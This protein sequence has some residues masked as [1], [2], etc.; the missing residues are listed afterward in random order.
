VEAWWR[1]G[2]PSRDGYASPLVG[3]RLERGSPRHQPTSPVETGPVENARIVP[4]GRGAR[5]PATPRREVSAEPMRG[6]F[7]AMEQFLTVQ[8]AVMQAALAPAPGLPSVVSLSA[9]A[10]AS[11]AAVAIQSGAI[12]R[13]AAQRPAPATA[14]EL[15]PRLAPDGRADWAARYPLLGNVTAYVQGQTLQAERRLTTAEDVF[16][17]DHRFTQ[18]ISADPTLEPVAVVPMTVSLEIMAEAAAALLPGLRVVG[19]RRVYCSRWITV[20]ERPTLLQIKARAVPAT[21]GPD[22]VEV[23]I[24]F[25]ELDDTSTSNEPAARSIVLLDRD[26]PD[27]GAAIPFA[28][29]N[30]R[31]FGLTIDQVHKYLFH[32]PRFRTISAVAAAGDDGIIGDLAVPPLDRFLGARGSQGLILDPVVLDGIGQLKV[33]WTYER[34]SSAEMLYPVRIDEFLFYGP[35]YT[36]P[37]TLRCHVHLL[38]VGDRRVRMDAEV[39]GPD[40]RVHIR[41]A[42]WQSIRFHLPPQR[43]KWTHWPA[44]A[45]A[46][47]RW[48]APVQALPAAGRYMAVLMDGLAERSSN[49][50]AEVIASII[51]NRAERD[52]WRSFAGSA[53]R[54]DEWLLG[55]SA[56]KDVTRMYLHQHYGLTVFP[57]D[58]EVGTNAR[59]RLMVTGPWTASLPTAPAVAFAQTGMIA[60]AIIGGANLDDYLGVALERIQPRDPAFLAR[61]FS[62]HEQRLLSAV[63]PGKR[64]EWEARLWCVKE[65]LANATGYGPI[66]APSAVSIG[67]VDWATGVV[68]AQVSGALAQREPQLRGTP[69]KVCTACAGGLVVASTT[70]ER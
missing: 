66:D 33:A 58:I 11:P 51:L 1:D 61:A 2:F 25:R 63:E 41:V 16:L 35:R 14:A 45:F 5:L 68:L 54:R 6:Y 29:T 52:L 39:L 48:D 17:Q 19:L 27:I 32:G 53:K 47:E 46:G 44:S 65:A 20:S 26:Y 13:P 3:E 42:G 12:Q 59:G 70:C 55:R 21:S 37:A 62:D 9:A 31:P 8:N 56:L 23:E 64:Q 43:A 69:I 57:A 22:Q 40:G 28:L 50:F 30:A 34:I 7:Q 10:Q 18:Q 4:E 24:R 49:V 36:A 15:D 60:V 67:A 38:E